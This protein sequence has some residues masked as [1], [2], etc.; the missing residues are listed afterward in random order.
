MDVDRSERLS[1]QWMFGA[2]CCLSAVVVYVFFEVSP[3][4]GLLM[5][6]LAARFGS[7]YI[8]H[9][10]FDDAPYWLRKWKYQEWHGNYHEFDGRQLRIDD[11]NRNLEVMPLIAVADLEN[12]FKDKARFR[13]KEASLPDSGLLEG[14][15]AIPA[16]RAVQWAR[17]I[18]RTGN[19]QAEQ[20]AKLALFIER[21]FV[22]PRLKEIRVAEAKAF[23]QIE[24]QS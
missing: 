8:V 21:S 19:S 6:P 11:F 1:K 17:V 3:I 23:E 20:A 14:V 18:S 15:P 7:R 4:L 2:F 13:I 24:R 9:A 10:A 16:D 12:L 5:L 22:Q